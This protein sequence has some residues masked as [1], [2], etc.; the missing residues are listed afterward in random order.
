MFSLH[1]LWRRCIVLLESMQEQHP[2][3]HGPLLIGAYNLVFSACARDGRWVEAQQVY[4]GIARAVALLP[5]PPWVGGAAKK[6]CSGDG[7]EAKKRIFRHEFRIGEFGCEICKISGISS[8]AQLREHLAGKTHRRA[9]EAAIERGE[10]V[11]EEW[12]DEQ[13]RRIGG[14]RALQWQYS[15]MQADDAAAGGGSLTSTEGTPSRAGYESA[16]E[17]AKNSPKNNLGLAL[18][19]GGCMEPVGLVAVRFLL[20]ELWRQHSPVSA[21]GLG[22]I[23]S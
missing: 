17:S 18:F 8:E 19:V 22:C 9:V 23:R 2:K 11:D 13:S 1:S 14:L 10:E 7:S 5:P 16:N 6:L 3:L 4:M 20:S 15:T 21:K 12:G